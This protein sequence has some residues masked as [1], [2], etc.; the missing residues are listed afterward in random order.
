MFLS[1]S[2]SF[3]KAQK[4]SS[5]DEM[6]DYARQYIGT[7]YLT[8]G[9][10]PKAF[11]CS[12]F[13]Q[14]CYKSLGIEISRVSRDQAN[15]GISVNLKDL[16]TG[17]LV[18]FK[19]SSKAGSI[20]HVG[21]VVK[22]TG[23]ASFDFIH[24]STSKGIVISNSE[25]SYYK[26]RYVKACRVVEEVASNSSKS[27]NTFGSNS[28]YST[29]ESGFS[30]NEKQKIS[31]RKKKKKNRKNKDKNSVTL[32]QSV[33]Q[34]ENKHGGVVF[35]RTVEPQPKVMSRAVI[36]LDEDFIDEP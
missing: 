27:D 3:A 7:P 29:N 6:V 19:G 30:G 23:D 34:S 4:C 15:D 33:S 26:L 2:I 31:N 24:A 32:V 35:V 22:K 36:V 21:I 8:G 14:Y 1:I 17:D 16:K 5:M 18:F 10:T 9:T 13:T 20:G 12:G 28:N 11:D 25:V